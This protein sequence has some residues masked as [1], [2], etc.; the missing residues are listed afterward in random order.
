MAIITRE[1]RLVARAYWMVSHRWLAI[2]GVA[3]I[4]WLSANLIDITINE[5]ALYLLS[6]GLIV[7]NL[8]TL[9]LLG[10][11]KKKYASKLTRPVKLIIHFQITCDLVILT[12]ILYF[13][14]GIENPFFFIY[15]FHM[16]ISSILLS[17]TG[18][19]IQTTIAL[20]LFGTLVF[21]DFEGIIMHHCLCI[22]GIPNHLLYKDLYYVART[23]GVFAFV[24]YT[25]VYLATSIGHRLRTQE[26]K[27]T[28]AIVKLRRQDEIKNQYV[29][30]ITH[31]IK[32]HLAAIQTSLSVLTDGVFGSLE[33]KQKEFLDRAYKRT[34]SL[35]SF[36]RNLLHLTQLKLINKVEKQEFSFQDI[37]DQTI[38]EQSDFAQEK[39]QSVQLKIDKGIGNYLGNKV[40]FKEVFDNLIG[41][42]IKYTA[43]KGVI[44]L[45]VSSSLDKIRIEVAD[46]GIGI[47]PRD[48]EKIFDEFQRGTNVKDLGVQGSGVGLSLVKEIVNNHDG[49]IWAENRKGKGSRFIIELPKIKLKHNQIHETIPR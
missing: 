44:E 29:L 31:D 30:R 23:F 36:S 42:A 2:L 35:V 20:G 12:G 4:T 19:F 8:I 39:E 40:S 32:S 37:I 18:A 17:K 5:W 38:S 43:Q 45:S 25:L 16:V 34:G 21:L 41:N 3:V 1:Q 6:V 47:P 11:V 48:L 26:D 28:D 22:D 13:T 49:K 27:L 33:G 10:F 9:A 24:S 46:S 7:E 14:G 15:I